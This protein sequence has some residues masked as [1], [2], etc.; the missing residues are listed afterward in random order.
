MR[1]YGFELGTNTEKIKEN[2]KIE[3]SRLIRLL[4]QILLRKNEKN[5]KEMIIIPVRC[6]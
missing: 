6:I 1:Y 4:R 3:L 5:E 2:A